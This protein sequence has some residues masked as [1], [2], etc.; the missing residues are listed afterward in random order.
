MKLA[1][2]AADGAPFVAAIHDGDRRAFD[3]AAAARRA[4]A[5]P[6][7]YATMLDLVAAGPEALSVAAGLLA[8]QAGD[9][10]LSRPLGAFRFLAPLPQPTQIRECALFAQHVRH[11]PAGMRRLAGEPDAQPLDAVPAAFAERPVFYF[12]NRMNVVG[13][14]AAIAWPGA[15]RVIDYELELGLV[16][17][18]GGRD[19]A[20]DAAA[21][22]I[23]GYTIYNDF[24]ARDLQLDETRAGFGPSKSKSF[25]GANALGPWIVTAD[26]IGDP[27]GLAVSV[28]INGETI[29]RSR[30]DGM[31]HA[32]ADLL[33]HLSRDERLFPGELIGFG[34]APA[35][36]GLELGRYLE[37]GD[38]VALTVERIG[39]LVNRIAPG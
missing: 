30:L 35:G 17:G 27:R 28:A 26:E 36:C 39:T 10:S 25:D 24:S 32:P 16:I 37:R 12:Q 9:E 6:S 21:R 2:L 3:L 38:T 13:H 33:A 1:T 7:L 19:I 8:A 34:T 31:L 4:G 23:F 5:D 22:H 20:P 29:A 14:G 15:S 11:A 18:R